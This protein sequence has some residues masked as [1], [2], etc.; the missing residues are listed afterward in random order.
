M[1]YVVW[2]LTGIAIVLG[3][4]FGVVL[5]IRHDY[6]QEAIGMLMIGYTGEE[7]EAAQMFLNL[8]KDVAHFETNDYVVLRVKRLRARK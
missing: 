3:F 7:D 5:G 1:V 4:L 2:G 8:S 6:G